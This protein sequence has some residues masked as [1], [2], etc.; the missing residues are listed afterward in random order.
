MNT[1]SAAAVALFWT[2]W[3]LDTYMLTDNKV[4]QKL[5]AKSKDFS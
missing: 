1:T 4:K 5:S 3:H 2:V